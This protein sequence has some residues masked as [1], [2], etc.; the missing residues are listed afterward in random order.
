MP[1]AVIKKIATIFLI[2]L[3]P[4]ALAA[5]AYGFIWWKV[6]SAA[7]D[8]AQQVS[9][10][11]DM[12][13]QNVHID[14]LGSEV[15]L[16]DVAF[17]PVGMEG[18]ID[19]ELVKIKAPSWG[20]LLDF[21]KKMDKGE[22]PES[23][24]LDMQGLT[25]DMASGYMQDWARMAESA[26]REAGQ[27][28]DTLAC[29]DLKYFSIADVR[30]MGYGKVRGDLALQYSF[31][32]VDKQINFDMQSDTQSM[33]GMSMSMDIQVS[34][35][36]LNLQTAMFAQPQLKRVEMR[37][38][39]RG[40]NNSRNRFCSKLNEE[41]VDAY[42]ERYRTLLAQRLS[43]EGWTIPEPILTAFD[44]V[45][46]PGGSMYV[47]VDIPDG[48]GTQHMMMVQKPTDLIDSLSP[49]VEF[50][51][52]PVLISGIE[53][54][55][56]DPNAI[57]MHE[58]MAAHS[59][60]GAKGDDA[61]AEANESDAIESLDLPAGDD[62]TD[63]AREGKSESQQ[64]AKLSKYKSSQRKQKLEKGFKQVELP[65]L[66]NHIGEQV[67]L[68]TYFGRKV[69]GALVAVTS[70]VVTVEHRLVDGRGTATYPIA[71]D[72]IQRAELFYQ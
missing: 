17:V 53:W 6:S 62:G 2:I 52:K 54:E 61:S 41:P 11:V 68:Y 3:T 44:S 19:L 71:M 22:I 69:E 46:D 58:A 13:Y 48:F 33:M 51:G 43:A 63:A 12:T 16:L 5:A 1:Q 36:K 27:G 67:I 7:D 25:L 26:Q 24:N 56:P 39:D 23:F 40:Y 38:F 15:G 34:S 21:Q 32:K 72:K 8:F 4:I 45:N 47:R 42:R 37:F 49:Y 9:P 14:L 66:A 57:S 31:D 10:F 65:I 28:Y 70:S 60:V 18:S 55:M 59:A 30:K 20:Y 29:G 50:N 35:D 64:L